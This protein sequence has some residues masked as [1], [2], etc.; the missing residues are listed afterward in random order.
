[1]QIGIP[2]VLN[3]YSTAPIW[4]TYFEAL[5]IPSDRIV[6][7]D[8][9]SEE[10]WAEGGKYGSIDPCYPSKVCQAH[11]HNLLVRNPHHRVDFIFF[12]C[13]THVPS[14]VVNT[15]DNTS[16]PIVAGA[17]KAVRAAFTKETD[18]FAA[19][20]IEVRGRR[21]DARRAELLRATNVRDVGRAVRDHGGRKRLGLP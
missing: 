6:F 17:P 21:R 20:G 16:C 3:I 12:P 14:F 8:Y 5:G 15:M 7:S 1:M 19:K 13:I 10:L 2:R 9:T 4:R 11:I 18:F